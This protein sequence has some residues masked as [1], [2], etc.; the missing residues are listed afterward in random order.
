MVESRW[1]AYAAHPSLTSSDSLD[2]EFSIGRVARFLVS[3]EI[4]PGAAAPPTI[5][6][7]PRPVPVVS[8]TASWNLAP[9]T[10]PQR[11]EFR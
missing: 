5:C 11:V 2:F 10:A 4:T 9:R 1:Q 8:L 3:A 7:S 6:L